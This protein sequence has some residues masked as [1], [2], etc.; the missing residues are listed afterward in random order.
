MSEH[1]IKIRP[2]DLSRG[3]PNNCIRRRGV[4]GVV[5]SGKFVVLPEW[6]TDGCGKAVVV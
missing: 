6:K 1:R 2:K 3:S 4:V 5:H